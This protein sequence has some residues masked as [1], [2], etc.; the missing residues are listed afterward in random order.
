MNAPTRV[1]IIA[2]VLV[3]VPLAAAT[4]AAAPG[5]L[6]H[7]LGLVD[8]RLRIAIEIAPAELGESLRTAEI[9]CGL[10]ERATAGQDA[11]LASADWLTLGQIIDQS[12]TAS[13]R[14]DTAFRNADAV[15]LRLR[16][17]YEGRWAEASGRLREL[18]RGVAS[19]RRGIAVMRAALAGLP[20]PLT[21]WRAHECEAAT[22]GVVQSFDRAPH[23]LKLIN[24][25]MLRL[26]RLPQAATP[27]RKSVR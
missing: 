26:W 27:A 22:R 13:Q 24:A 5:P 12:V 6:R 10:G 3:A 16:E 18:R 14:V 11:E 15:L 2:A 4:A 21:S 25:G 19:T 17:R 7:D 20:T 8:S 1:R 9:V 23:G